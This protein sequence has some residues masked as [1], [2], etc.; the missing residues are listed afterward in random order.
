MPSETTVPVSKE[1][2]KLVNEYKKEFA[3]KS[4]DESVENAIRWAKLWNYVDSE[5][6]RTMIE[7]I[8]TLEFRI[9]ALEKFVVEE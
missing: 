7:R 5:Q 3:F 1:T 4:L 2:L 8:N 6:R 9:T